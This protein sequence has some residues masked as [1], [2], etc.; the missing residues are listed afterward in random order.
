[1]VGVGFELS[2][3]LTKSKTEFSRRKICTL[4]VDQN[5]VILWN[6]RRFCKK[7]DHKHG[8][9]VAANQD[10]YL[11]NIGNL[12]S[13]PTEGVLATALEKLRA[14]EVNKK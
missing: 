9:V 6:C 10:N 13:F 5:L 4:Q 14:L 3:L 7:V 2:S 12:R 1:M 11:Q 8:K